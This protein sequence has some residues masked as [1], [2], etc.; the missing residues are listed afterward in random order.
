MHQSFQQVVRARPNTT[1]NGGGGEDRDF[2]SFEES[3]R[4]VGRTL[5][6]VFETAHD[7]PHG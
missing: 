2:E 6:K 7:P 4:E 3:G 1:R 5:A